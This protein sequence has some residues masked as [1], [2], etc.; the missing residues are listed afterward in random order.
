AR[1][2]H[3]NSQHLSHDPHGLARKIREHLC[4]EANGA[5]PNLDHCPRLEPGRVAGVE[6]DPG[7]PDPHRRPTAQAIPA[8]PPPTPAGPATKPPP[9]RTV[10]HVLGKPAENR[11]AR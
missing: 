10:P 5:I 8:D 9:T 3:R 2:Y 1:A 6:D 7:G 11:P 4:Q